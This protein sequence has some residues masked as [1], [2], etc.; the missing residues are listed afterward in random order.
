MT[1]P[2]TDIV[3]IDPLAP[4][5]DSVD[6]AAEV[7]R[8]GGLVACP[9]ETV[10]GLMADA[11]NA[12]AVRRVFGAKGRPV[13]QP[14]PV[15]VARAED[16]DGLCHAVP[17]AARRLIA[18]F[19]PGP[20][21]LVMPRASSVSDIITGGTDTVGIR[22]PDY[23][24]TLAV[25]R[26]LG[27]PVVCP[28]ANA[29]GRRASITAADVRTDLDGQIDLI[30]DGGPA[31]GGIASTVLDVTVSPARILREGAISRAALES[32]LPIAD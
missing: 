25:L 11:H 14:L 18:A 16:I 22:M 4:D 30:L 3:K 1:R 21:T 17:P 6:R 28:S 23:P 9:T 12:D 7:L 5:P 13:G 27:G 26:A 20:L 19:F 15:Q 31:P 2:S 29:T 10:Y 24:V 8:G 32:F